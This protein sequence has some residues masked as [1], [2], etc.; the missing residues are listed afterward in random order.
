MAQVG[1]Y[2]FKGI[3]KVLS[4]R[5]L[6]R[7]RTHPTQSCVGFAVVAE[8]NATPDGCTAHALLHSSSSLRKHTRH[9]T[10]SSTA[11][12]LS[13]VSK[14]RRRRSAVRRT[15][16]TILTPDYQPLTTSQRTS[17]TTVR[18]LCRNQST[19]PNVEKKAVECWSQSCQTIRV[20]PIVVWISM[21]DSME[22][23]YSMHGHTRSLSCE[24]SF[25]VVSC[26]KA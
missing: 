16:S 10:Q 5:S 24:Y 18:I 23:S 14:I 9:T 11:T 8:W 25:F 13:S 15:I 6:V 22:T 7:P 20:L 3:L 1:C 12:R 19:L 17:W 21:V 26:E 4:V 2:F